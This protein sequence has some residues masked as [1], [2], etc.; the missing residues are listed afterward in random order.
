M[1]VS[2]KPSCCDSVPPCLFLLVPSLRLIL[3]R[4]GLLCLL[5]LNLR[6]VYVMSGVSVMQSV[7]AVKTLL[8]LIT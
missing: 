6:L 3:L 7:C 5:L 1:D 8:K 4:C 2:V